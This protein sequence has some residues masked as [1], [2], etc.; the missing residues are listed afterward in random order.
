MKKADKLNEVN[1]R[2]LQMERTI[3][4][5][6]STLNIYKS[7]KNI[8]DEISG[9]VAGYRRDKQIKEIYLGGK[10]S[11]RRSLNKKKLNRTSYLPSN[12]RKNLSVTR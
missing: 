7:N 2:K 9:D 4:P 12:K 5:E 10:E 8:L 1:Y 3:V 11:K 6:S